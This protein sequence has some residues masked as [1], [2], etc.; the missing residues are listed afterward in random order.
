MPETV[1][2]INGVGEKDR[3]ELR[4]TYGGITREKLTL[5]DKVAGKGYEINV[6]HPMVKHMEFVDGL[7][8][9]VRDAQTNKA[10]SNFHIRKANKLFDA[11]QTIA[12]GKL[13]TR[14]AI[15]EFA[16]EVITQT[17]EMD[18]TKEDFK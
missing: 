13:E 10:R 1:K 4:W 2:V 8:E 3:F 14:E 9:A 5:W 17:E 15:M 16:K 12:R 6:H 11:I 18:Y 7:N